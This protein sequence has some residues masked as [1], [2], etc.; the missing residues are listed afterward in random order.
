MVW[1]GSELQES[2]QWIYNLSP[3]DIEEILSG[4]EHCKG[5]QNINSVT[6][7]LLKKLR[8]NFSL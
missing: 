4:L 8:A 2:N 6:V 5:K 1:S 3:T 7:Y